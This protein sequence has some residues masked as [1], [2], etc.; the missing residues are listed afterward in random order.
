MCTEGAE[1]EHKDFPR[2]LIATT[3]LNFLIQRET[4]MELKLTQLGLTHLDTY[5]FGTTSNRKELSS[6]QVLDVIRYRYRHEHFIQWLRFVQATDDQ[7]YPDNA[8]DLKKFTIEVC[9]PCVIENSHKVC[10]LKFVNAIKQ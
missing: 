7:F 6:S 8:I 9:F 10:S 4:K 2:R 1:F 5:A 3:A